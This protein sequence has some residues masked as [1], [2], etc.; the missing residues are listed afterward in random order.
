MTISFVLS[1]SSPRK[2]LRDDFDEALKRPSYCRGYRP[3]FNLLTGHLSPCSAMSRKQKGLSTLFPL[4]LRYL[5]ELDFQPFD[6][7]LFAVG[8][9]H[10]VACDN[11][12]IMEGTFLHTHCL[13]FSMKDI[14][15]SPWEVKWFPLSFHYLSIEG[16]QWETIAVFLKR[17]TVRES[18][19]PMGG[20]I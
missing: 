20:G 14:I 8:K 12:L 13:R 18:G 11:E 10:T 9:V 3:L 15:I 1:V 6:S 7:C 2:E 19:E 5:P 16:K 4:S 17:P